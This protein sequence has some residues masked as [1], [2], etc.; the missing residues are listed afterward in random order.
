LHK[1]KPPATRTASTIACHLKS[2][3]TAVVSDLT[4]IESTGAEVVS[5]GATV[6]VSTVAGIESFALEFASELSLQATNAPIAKTNMSFFIV[7]SFVF[8]KDYFLFIPV[9]QKGNPLTIK[10]LKI[11]PA[12]VTYS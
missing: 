11:V 3:L 7:P 5:T 1:K 9:P 10:I 4:P 8:F 12:G 2:Y 6:F